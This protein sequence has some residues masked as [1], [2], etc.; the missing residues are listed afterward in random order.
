MKMLLNLLQ[1]S[2]GVIIL[3]AIQTLCKVVRSE[4]MKPCWIQF[5]E[6]I[7]LKI[8]DSYRSNRE[9]VTLIEHSIPKIASVL[10]LDL[11][12][13]ILNPVI[14][15]G[16]FPTNLCAV[17]ILTEL[18][19]KQGENFTEQH[20]DVIMPNIALLYLV[21]GEEKVKPKFSMLTGSKVRLLNVYINKFKGHN[22]QEKS[23]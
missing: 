5:L 9:V 16:E 8:I 19:S 1:S 7:L 4:A 14:A 2:D 10:P 23:S 22:S 15:T 11:S 18:A 20:L 17:K 13:N 21:M 12:I 3:R 6:L